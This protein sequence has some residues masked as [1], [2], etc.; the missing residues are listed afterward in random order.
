MSGTE[1]Q[2]AYAALLRELG[3]SRKMV[4]STSLDG[5]VTSRMM[6]VVI[7]GGRLYFQTDRTLRKYGQLKGNA[8]VA[9][10]ADNVQIQGRCEEA[11]HPLENAA[12]CQAYRKHF[13]GSYEAYTALKNER[14]FIVAPTL[15]ER[16]V[17]LDGVPYLETFD[18][19]KQLHSLTRYAGE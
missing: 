7:M 10:C 2:A 9:L 14:L 8:N 17:Y 18:V 15:I 5:V 4:L 1:Y 19:T 11:G 6:S 13:P 3:E 12:F 16:W